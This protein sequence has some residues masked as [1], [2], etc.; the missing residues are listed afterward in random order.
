MRAFHCL[1]SAGVS[2]AIVLGYPAQSIAAFVLPGT[3]GATNKLDIG[4]FSGGT[5]LQLNVTGTVNLLP[6]TGFDWI[7]NPD[8]SLVSFTYPFAYQYALAGSNLYPTLA[9]GDG[10]NH[11][12][13]GGANYDTAPNPVNGPFGFAGLE[14]TDTTNP[15]AIRFGAVV[16]TFSDNPTRG[17]W[18][19]LG[20]GGQIVTPTGGG[21]LYL[22][23]QDGNNDTFPGVNS[24]SYLVDV[25]PV[26]EPNSLIVVGSGALFFGCRRILTRRSSR[27]DAHA[28]SD[29][30]SQL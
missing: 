5:V 27:R 24:G 11:F 8:G 21:H 26:P 9:G 13:G 2:L 16:Y 30:Q 28:I 15:G 18:H 4:F 25:S 10:V 3:T 23:V 19:Y 22:A 6:Q 20:Y 17:D 1:V 12:V 29:C 7:T 14:T